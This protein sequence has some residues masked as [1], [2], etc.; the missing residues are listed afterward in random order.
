MEKHHL[1]QKYN[2]LILVKVCLRVNNLPITSFNGTTNSISRILYAIPPYDNS[3]N[4]EGVV[5]HAPPE[6]TYIKLNNSEKLMLNELDTDIVDRED[7]LVSKG[8]V[9]ANTTITYHIRKSRDPI[10]NQS[11]LF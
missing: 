1:L 5:Y 11:Q 7:K 10:S 9:I 4:D 6:K 2:L 3:G 8:D